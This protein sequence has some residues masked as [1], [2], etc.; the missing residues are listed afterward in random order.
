MKRSTKKCRRFSIEWHW[1]FC[2]SLENNI[3]TVCWNFWDA[4]LPNLSKYKQNEKRIRTILYYIEW[5]Q[6]HWNILT[7]G[8]DH[9]LVT[10]YHLRYKIKWGIQIDTNIV[11]INYTILILNFYKV[12]YIHVDAHANS[13]TRDCSLHTPRFCRISIRLV[14]RNKRKKKFSLI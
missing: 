13:H 7:L 2:N 14:K 8:T 3:F 9:F 4:L 12:R 10:L 1:L 11:Q 6:E 5:Y